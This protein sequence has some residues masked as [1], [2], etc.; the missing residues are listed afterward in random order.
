MRNRALGRFFCQE[1]FWVTGIEESGA[2]LE[3][4]RMK[5]IFNA[6][7]LKANAGSLSF[8]DQGFSVISSVT[9]FPFVENVDCI[10]T[11]VYC[12]VSTKELRRWN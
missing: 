2:I 10:S 5:N 11:G 9:M 12:F 1:G 8:Q 7:F 6:D 3:Q 4:A